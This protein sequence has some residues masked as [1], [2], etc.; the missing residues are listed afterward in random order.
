MLDKLESNPSAT[1]P[2]SGATPN[3]LSDLLPETTEGLLHSAIIQ[4][5][6][7]LRLSGY[8]ESA[9]FMEV[10]ALIMEDRQNH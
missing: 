2:L 1:K 9:H 8:G 6:K 10:A 4:F 3:T 7:Q 5:A